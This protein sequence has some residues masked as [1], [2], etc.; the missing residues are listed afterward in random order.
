MPTPPAWIEHHRP[1]DNELLGWIA[2]KADGFIPINL[3]G[4]AITDA[5]DRLDAEGS[6]DELGISYLGDPFELL[7]DGGEWLCVRIVEVSTDAIRVKKEDWG[8]IDSPQV[9]YTLSF[10]TPHSLRS[11]G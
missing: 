2:P 3:L 7:T 1:S 6:L 11:V 9:L 4:H 5:T 8:A 10:P